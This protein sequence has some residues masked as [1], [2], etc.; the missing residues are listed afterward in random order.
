MNFKAAEHA[1]GTHGEYT[2]FIVKGLVALW[3]GWWAHAMLTM[4]TCTT[5]C[6][7]RNRCNRGRVDEQGGWCDAT[8]YGILR[9]SCKGELLRQRACIGRTVVEVS[10]LQYDQCHSYDIVT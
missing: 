5:S 8:E 2:V 1:D 10:E 6:T 3:A 9:I 7:G 4:Q